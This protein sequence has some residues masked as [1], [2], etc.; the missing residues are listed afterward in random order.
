M[1]LDKE[2]SRAATGALQ[3]LRSSRLGNGKLKMSQITV[4]GDNNLIN[5]GTGG[6]VKVN[7]GGAADYRLQSGRTS[8]WP[9]QI[10]DAIRVKATRDRRSNNELCELA[11]RVLGRAVVTLERL[12]AR[13]LGRVYEAMCAGQ[14]GA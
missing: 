11:G 7:S 8:Q 5:V 4:R 2:C 12:S 13:E 14:R 3:S 9:Q 10:L 1:H 6:T